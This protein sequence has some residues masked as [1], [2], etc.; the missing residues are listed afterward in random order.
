M[1]FSGYIARNLL[2]RAD[3]RN[4]EKIPRYRDA[5]GTHSQVSSHFYNQ[6]NNLSPGYDITK[7]R[8]CREHPVTL[9]EAKEPPEEKGSIEK[10]ACHN[11][12]KQRGYDKGYCWGKCN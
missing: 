4:H 8:K 3:L 1:I 10:R 12:L 9:L 5:S 2:I 6:L 7:L 11:G